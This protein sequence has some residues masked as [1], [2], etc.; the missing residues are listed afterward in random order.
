MNTVLTKGISFFS[1]LLFYS[2]FND[3]NPDYNLIKKKLTKD[4]VS[5]FMQQNM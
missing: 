2:T 5:N 4:I 1:K 3:Y